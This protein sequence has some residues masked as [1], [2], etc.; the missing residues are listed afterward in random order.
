MVTFSLI[1]GLVS[2]WD[3]YN[4]CFPPDLGDLEVAHAGR[5]EIVEPGFQS[6][7]GVVY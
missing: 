4:Y 2:L 6:V 3:C 5:E 1:Q 7:I